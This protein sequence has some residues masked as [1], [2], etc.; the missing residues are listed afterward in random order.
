MCTTSGQ[1]HMQQQTVPVAVDS[2]HTH[3]PLGPNILITR[4]D[5]IV[6]AVYC[7][8]CYY[9][10][11]CLDV[12]TAL[13]AECMFA[14]RSEFGLL[15][16]GNLIAALQLLRNITTMNQHTQHRSEGLNVWS[17]LPKPAVMSLSVLQSL[18]CSCITTYTL[19]TFRSCTKIPTNRQN[20]RLWT[21]YHMMD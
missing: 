20:L 5:C 17:H 12:R 13:T 14:I 10:P 18:S 4:L 1:R 2:S 15:L 9:I 11:D 16:H 19:A 6:L 3:C 7:L 8:V 21:P